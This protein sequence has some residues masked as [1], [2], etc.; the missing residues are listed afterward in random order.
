MAL[1]SSIYQRS[2]RIQ[3]RPKNP[4]DKSTII[5]VY[6]YEIRVHN[7]TSFPSDHVIPAAPD[8]DF[9]IAIVESTYW[10]KEMGEGQPYLEVPTD[11]IRVAESII[12]DW[13]NSLPGYIPNQADAGLFFIPGPFTKETIL[14]FVDEHGKKFP[15]LLEEARIRQK[16]WYGGLVN[17]AD[18]DWARTSG[19]PLAVSNLSRMA[20]ERLGLKDK[21]WMANFAAIEKKNC[22]FCGT[23]LNP[24]FPICPNCKSVVNE[25]RAKELGMK[26]V[27]A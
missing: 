13:Q 11:S 7:H 18:K 5:S 20:A 17:L 16:N 14:K 6:P 12:R 15:Q 19:N 8:G 25:T 21:L 24:A 3:R 9:A 4:L 26:V 23:L 2:S 27:S 1:P 10:V 22:Q